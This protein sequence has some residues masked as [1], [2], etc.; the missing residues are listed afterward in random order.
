[1]AHYGIDIASFQHPG[2]AGIDYTAAVADLRARG[3][4]AQPFVIVKA[5]EAANYVNPYWKADVAGFVAAGAAVAVYLFDEGTAD[6]ASEYAYA[7]S[8]VGASLP[9]EFDIEDPAGLSA[10]AYAAHVASLVGQEPSGLAY[11]NLSELESLPGAPWG[12]PL[13]LANPGVAAPQVP[14]LI[15]QYGTGSVAGIQGNVDLDLFMGTD[16]QLVAVF[17]GAPTPPAPP[18]PPPPPPPP[19]ENM[20][21]CSITLT[22][23]TQIHGDVMTLQSLLMRKG[24]ANLGAT[25]A[26]GR[27]GAL[28]DRAVRDWQAF[29]HLTVDG[30][31]GPA[32]W[33]TL[34][35]LPIP[36]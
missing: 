27:F 30:I 14:C 4:G 9:V 18:P 11:L 35:H 33:A 15:W 13:W 24:N 28:T 5:T 20:I 19:E 22:P 21:T 10:S 6:P 36:A 29:F 3:N 32:T 25:G 26:D 31:A 17:G 23:A 16:A 7:R 2:G 12:H 8:I 34:L 1:M